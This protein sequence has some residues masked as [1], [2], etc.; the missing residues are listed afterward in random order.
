[1][2]TCFLKLMLWWHIELLMESSLTWKIK[3][4]WNLFSQLDNCK[5]RRN[6]TITLAM[7][8][9]IKSKAINNKA[10]QAHFK[11]L[12]FSKTFWM[13]LFSFNF[14]FFEKSFITNNFLSLNITSP[15]PDT[16]HIELFLQ[17]YWEDFLHHNWWREMPGDF[18]TKWPS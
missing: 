3:I 10:V 1:M 16:V 17:I 11:N 8:S 9:S 2:F 18:G 15:L 12:V 13:S 5:N 4:L 7:N 6:Q 14:F